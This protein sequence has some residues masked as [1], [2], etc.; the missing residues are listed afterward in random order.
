MAL[1]K[2]STVL[3]V[4]KTEAS[5]ASGKQQW[6]PKA[7]A[8]HVEYV[9]LREAYVKW[10]GDETRSST[11]YIAQWCRALATGNRER[12]GD[13]LAGDLSFFEQQYGKESAALR[14]LY[15]LKCKDLVVLMSTPG[16]LAEFHQLEPDAQ[17]DL[18]A[19]LV[20]RFGESEVGRRHFAAEL[21]NSTSLLMTTV[22]KATRKANTAFWRVLAESG[23]T[24][25]ILKGKEAVEYIEKL[26]ISKVDIVKPNLLRAQ[27]ELY[28]AGSIVPV[29]EARTI[30]V[31]A[32]EKVSAFTHFKTHRTLIGQ[33]FDA[34]NLALALWTLKEKQGAKE[35]VASVGA[36]ASF[37]DKLKK[38]TE[39]LTKLGLVRTA[40]KA[41]SA[42]VLAIVAGIC[43]A[44]TGSIDAHDRWSKGDIDAAVAYG[45]G[46]AAGATSAIGAGLIIWGAGTS[47]AGVGVVLLVAGAIVSLVSLLAGFLLDDHPLELWVS[48]CRFGEDYGKNSA[49]RSW[50]GKPRVQVEALHNII[51]GMEF[52]GQFKSNFHK[53]TVR[54]GLILTCSKVTVT[55]Q[56]NWSLG[57]M[58]QYRDTPVN[59]RW[60][61]KVDGDRVTS[62][63]IHVDQ[64]PRKELI[65][66]KID[67]EVTVDAYNDGKT[68]V[69][70]RKQTLTPSL[71]ERVS[72]WF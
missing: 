64:P 33:T 16:F 39:V 10:A 30:T 32:Q 42:T 1:R 46:A 61:V 62:F 48:N 72:S 66:D 25:T 6:I 56:S 24:I 11:L 35:V 27:W 22:F 20:E 55:V 68:L 40:G 34:L 17:D 29:R 60:D 69:Y 2:T 9:Q 67:V 50:V 19:E 65:F 43:E 57:G 47:W 8:L 13:R 31:F 70:T 26:I 28:P 53:V 3:A 58:C 38:S 51:T 59:E 44:I 36:L 7:R 37:A 15:E 21:K 18:F 63:V 41:T 14:K 49:Y 54:P 45:T 5:T 12:F 52:E 23:A 71:G 4:K